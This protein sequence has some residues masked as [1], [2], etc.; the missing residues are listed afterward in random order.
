[1]LTS[2]SAGVSLNTN[3]ATKSA[4]V[5]PY[6][7]ARQAQQAKAPFNGAAP[8]PAHASGNGYHRPS[9]PRAHPRPEL[10]RV[11]PSPRR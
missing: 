10:G 11:P 6:L 9:Y 3:N 5:P 2:F 7:R 8:T 4:Y 1:M